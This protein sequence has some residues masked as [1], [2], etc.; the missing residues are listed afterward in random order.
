MSEPMTQNDATADYWIRDRRHRVLGPVSLEVL[1]DLVAVGRLRHVE[2]ISLD[3]QTFGAL[4]D[5][6][7]L[8]DLVAAP[9]PSARD[10]STQDQDQA[11]LLRAR[12]A[13]LRA[14]PDSEVFKVPDTAS[15]QEFLSAF[16]ALAKE[17]HPDRVPAHFPELHAAS[18]DLLHFVT[19][20]INNRIRAAHARPTALLAA[21]LPGPKLFDGS[22][23]VGLERN[24]AGRTQATVRITR[25]SVSMFTRHSMINLSNSGIFLPGL[26]AP[27]GNAIDLLFRFVAPGRD[28]RTTGKVVW[29]NAANNRHPLGSGVRYGRLPD[30]ETAF[31]I[32]Y[33]GWTVQ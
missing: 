29:E 7:G 12:L 30:D 26:H 25:E 19:E 6:P 3:G 17:F 22:Q 11:N 28:I 33:V 8:V 27:L 5:F 32:D 2:G 18:A 21:P 15:P 1:K 23:F 4:A 13:R 10:L 9:A 20:R 31:I 16:F 14:L 24:Q